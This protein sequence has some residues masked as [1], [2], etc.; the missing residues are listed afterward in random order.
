MSEVKDAAISFEAKALRMGK[1]VKDGVTLVLKAHNDDSA[2]LMNDIPLGRS[3]QVAVVVVGDDGE[4]EL[5]EGQ[6]AVQKAGMLCRDK[7]FWKYLEL[8]RGHVIESESDCA[9]RLRMYLVAMSRSEIETNPYM[10]K[11]FNTLVYDY[12]QSLLGP[13]GK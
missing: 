9:H 3:L 1:T 7:K 8:I 12:Q 11:L 6:R 5:T 4:P 13:M 10:L 2:R